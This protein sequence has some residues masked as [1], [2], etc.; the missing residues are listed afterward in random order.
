MHGAILLLELSIWMRVL[1]KVKYAFPCLYKQSR[2]ALAQT[3]VDNHT[4]SKLLEVRELL[5]AL[6]YFKPIFI[7]LV[8]TCSFFSFFFF[9]YHKL[10]YWIHLQKK[11]KSKDIFRSF[12][13]LIHFVGF[14][15]REANIN[16]IELATIEVKKWTV[17]RI[18]VFKEYK[19]INVLQKLKLFENGVFILS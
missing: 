10:I 5:E 12:Q 19:T 7:N 13:S 3:L 9:F 11:I 16:N 15:V 6:L 1:H 17:G 4:D 14:E 8:G 2:I 18:L